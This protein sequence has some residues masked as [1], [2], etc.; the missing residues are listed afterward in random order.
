MA[1]AANADDYTK[2]RL[3]IFFTANGQTS[4]DGDLTGQ[5]VTLIKWFMQE[6]ANV[7]NPFAARGDARYVGQ[8]L[9]AQGL[10][11]EVPYAQRK[12]GD[13]VCYEYGTY[14]HISVQLSG[15]RVLEENVNFGGV[16]RRVLSD[17]TVV[18]ASRIGNE[19]E[20]FRQNPHVYRLKSYKEGGSEMITD[21]GVHALFKAILKHDATD[22]D[23]AYW[24]AYKSGTWEDVVDGLTNLGEY[25]EVNQTFALGEQAKAGGTTA[26]QQK[27]DQ[28]KQIVN[29]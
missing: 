24:K 7:P 13:I 27:L 11:D 16:A 6:M 8:N 12:R 5:C 26:A 17:G 21:N 29:S 14:G 23:V 18:Y 20:A 25:A 22:K 28:V 9:V 1:V 4:A 3:N 2:G 15:G 19:T 10:A